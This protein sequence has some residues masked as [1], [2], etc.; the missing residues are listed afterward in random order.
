MWICVSHMYVNLKSLYCS[1]EINTTLQNNRTAK[2]QSMVG[3]G[4]GRDID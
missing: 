4:T 1:G 3:N 2:N